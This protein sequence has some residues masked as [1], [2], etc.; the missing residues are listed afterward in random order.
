MR[1]LGFFAIFWFDRNRE[2]KGESSPKPP[3][4]CREKKTVI[5]VDAV[6]EAF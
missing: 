3:A 1:F 6:I 5:L 4:A 2:Q